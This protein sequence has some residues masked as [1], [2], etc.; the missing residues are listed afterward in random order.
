MTTISRNPRGDKAQHPGRRPGRPDRDDYCDLLSPL[1]GGGARP[2]PSRGSTTVDRRGSA[3][4]QPGGPIAAS[5]NGG[6]LILTSNGGIHTFGTPWYGSDGGKLPAGVTPVG[7]AAAPATGGYWILKSNG[8]VDSF[9]APW[10]GSLNGT[11]GGNTVTA[12]AGE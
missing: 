4:A 2:R 1:Q 9:H 11:P 7:L 10:H 8:G 12:I 3:R 5:P 6:Y